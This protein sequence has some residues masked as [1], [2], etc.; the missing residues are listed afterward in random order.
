M[1]PAAFVDSELTD[2]ALGRFQHG[3]GAGE[4]G[5][6]AQA[7]GLAL[8]EA[9]RDLVADVFL[10]AAD[11]QTL[12]AKVFGRVVVGV[13]DGRR[14][15]QAHQRREAA[16]RAVMQRGRQ[17]HQGVGPGGQK[18]R[19]TG[20]ARQAGLTCTGSDVVALVDD[21]DSNHAHSKQLRY[22]RLLVSASMEMM[23]RSK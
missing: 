13:R 20:P 16:R 14:I 4:Q 9:G 1:I 6:L 5:L 10:E 23:L 22:S 11:D 12:A 7:G 17:Q 18:T 19:Q 8:L 2:A 3:L 15:Q 21:D